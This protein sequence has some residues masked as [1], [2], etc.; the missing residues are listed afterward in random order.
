MQ[1]DVAG[2]ETAVLLESAGYMADSPFRKKLRFLPVFHKSPVH[3]QDRMYPEDSESADQK[4]Y[5]KN[6]G[7]VEQRVF[8]SVRIFT[9]G[10][11]FRKL[12]SGVFMALFAGSDKIF[13]MDCRK[14]I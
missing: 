10:I 14:G 8:F 6:E 2:V 12:W 1:D 13:G 11:E 5:H 9:V 3:P 7:P 4:A